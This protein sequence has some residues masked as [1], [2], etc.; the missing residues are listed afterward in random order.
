M[1]SRSSDWEA[2]NAYVDGELD[3]ARTA[4]VAERKSVV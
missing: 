2:L 1:P 4:E 3:P